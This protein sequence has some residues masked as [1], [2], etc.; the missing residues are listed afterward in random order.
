[1]LA[2]RNRYSLDG[3]VP[4]G[5]GSGTGQLAGSSSTPLAGSPAAHG[6]TRCG[7][8]TP[9]WAARCPSGTRRQSRRGAEIAGTAEPARVRSTLTRTLRVGFGMVVSDDDAAGAAGQ[10]RA[11]NHCGRPSHALSR[12][13]VH[14]AVACGGQRVSGRLFVVASV[15]C[16]WPHIV[17]G[18]R[19][20]ACSR[21][22]RGCRQIHRP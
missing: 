9:H 8:L 17:G 13:I 2:E 16:N 14:S 1:V 10:A 15:E 4:S 19:A 20:G 7:T 18:E 22:R 12:V 11:E 3:P 5:N 6:R 21:S